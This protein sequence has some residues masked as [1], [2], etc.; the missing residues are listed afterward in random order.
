MH[1]RTEQLTFNSSISKLKL[2]FHRVHIFN[3]HFKTK[4]EKT[5]F[6]NYQKSNLYPNIRIKLLHFVSLY[7][8]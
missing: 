4:Q 3:T 1:N 7:T 5:P 6:K 2:N 8:F